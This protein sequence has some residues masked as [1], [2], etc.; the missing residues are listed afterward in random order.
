M[1]KKLM[2]PRELSNLLKIPVRG[3]YRLI[4]NGELNSIRIGRRI[5]IDESEI[6]RILENQK[7]EVNK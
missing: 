2:T 4:Y 1:N 5:R 3:V 6:Q 7:L